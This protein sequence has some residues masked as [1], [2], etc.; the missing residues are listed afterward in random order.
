MS[1]RAKTVVRFLLHPRTRYALAWFLV[2][3]V[4]VADGVVAWKSQNLNRRKD[5]N[6]GHAL[7]DFGGQWL[8]GHMLY[9]GLGQHLYHREYERKVLTEAY[10][11]ADE[12]PEEDRDEKDQGQSDVENLMGWFMGAD[13]P[14]QA[15]AIGSFLAPLAGTNAWD[16]LALVRAEMEDEEERLAQASMVSVGGPLYPP[17]HAF[18]MS[19]FGCFRPHT[20]YRMLQMLGILAAPI[21]GCGISLL[22]RGRVWWPVA[23]TGLLIFP[24]FAHNLNLGQNGVWTMVLLIW[25]W[26]MIARGRSVWGGIIWGLI[27]FKPVWAAAFFLVPLLTGRWRVCLAMVITGTCLCAATLPVVGWKTWLDWLQ[28]GHMAAILYKV[29]ENWIFLSRDLVSLPRRWLLNF[30]DPPSDAIDLAATLIGW[31]ALLAVIECT[32]R[33]AIFRTDRARA[34]TGPAAAFLFLGAWFSCFHFMYYDVVLTALPV[35]LLL[36]NY[37][38]YLQPRYLAIARVSPAQLP[39]KLEQYYRARLASG[40]PSAFFHRHF[41]SVNICVLNSLTLSLIALFVISDFLLPAVPMVVSISF[42]ALRK[43]LVP[44]PLKFSTDVMGTPWSVFCL[45]ALWFWCGWLW[46]RCPEPGAAAKKL[47]E[48]QMPRSAQAVGAQAT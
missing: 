46:L 7:V 25:G 26:T 16:C 12:V 5:G 34:L 11:R 18:I 45:L 35:M 47:E 2:L 41:G 8:L 33:I 27:A 43:G 24:G 38:D 17:I 40:L 48:G 28:V 37:G 21:A 32:V 1:T 14:A 39:Q 31:A 9:Q 20:A 19:P 10:P 23:T 42:P 36:V 30:K 13:D 22:A 3:N 15:Q 44:M 6:N 29:D 4:A